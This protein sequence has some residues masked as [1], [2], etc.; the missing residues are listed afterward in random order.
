MPEVEARILLGNG[1]LDVGQHRDR[2]FIELLCWH[3]LCSTTGRALR[4]T[5]VSGLPSV[6]GSSIIARYDVPECAGPV[7]KG[8]ERCRHCSTG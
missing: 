7:Q 2:G 1:H 3:G 8:A 6:K 4:I 5:S